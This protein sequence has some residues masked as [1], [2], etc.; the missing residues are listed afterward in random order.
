MKNVLFNHALFYILQ[1]LNYFTLIYQVIH[2][3]LWMKW[4][5]IT[6]KWKSINW[7]QLWGLWILLISV[8][9]YKVYNFMNDKQTFVIKIIERRL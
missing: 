3:K 7:I 4:K 9:E 1:L 5:N 2:K 8:S 6:V